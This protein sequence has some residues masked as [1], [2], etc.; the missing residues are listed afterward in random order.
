MPNWEEVARR[1][2][3]DWREMEK[4]AFK[5]RQLLQ[6]FYTFNP[7]L[8]Q[9][10]HLVMRMTY[11]G[12]KTF[13]A[14][15]KEPAGVWWDPARIPFVESGKHYVEEVFDDDRFPSDFHLWSFPHNQE[16]VARS[17]CDNYDHQSFSAI[18]PARTHPDLIRRID[19][20]DPFS[21]IKC[22]DAFQKFLSELG[23]MVIILRPTG[24]FGIFVT[25]S[26]YSGLIKQVAAAAEG[27]GVDCFKLSSDGER[28]Y[29]PGPT[30]WG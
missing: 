5:D 6:A 22:H 19:R 8:G 3:A 2:L 21:A 28:F 26:D 24:E 10:P 27:A 13:L 9:G 15:V 11:L 29:W 7:A 12:V 16:I 20:L 23:W 1:A 18:I 25:T 30:E 14:T 4:L 17:A